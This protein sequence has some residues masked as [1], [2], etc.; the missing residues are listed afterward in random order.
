MISFLAQIRLIWSWARPIFSKAATEFLQLA[1]PIA[2]EAIKSYVGS[3]LKNSSKRVNA[4]A[5]MTANIQ[6][7]LPQNGEEISDSLID[8]AF[9]MAY[10]KLKEDGKLITEFTK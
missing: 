7:A 4:I 5:D 10:R 1:L 3:K 6:K 9:S 2:E 8:L